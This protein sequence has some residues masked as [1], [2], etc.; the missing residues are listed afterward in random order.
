M[1]NDESKTIS[2]YIQ[3]WMEVDKQRSLCS[4]GSFTV[5]DFYLLLRVISGNLDNY[6]VFNNSGGKPFDII[7]METDDGFKDFDSF[8]NRFKNIT[9]FYKRDGVETILKPL[10][11]Y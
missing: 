2:K 9:F 8:L 5:N 7:E 11:N 3:E 10:P 4:C 1:P 6:I